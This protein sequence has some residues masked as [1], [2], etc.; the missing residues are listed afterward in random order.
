MW[1]VTVPAGEIRCWLFS[2]FKLCWKRSS[3]SVRLSLW[4][5]EKKKSGKFPPVSAC[6]AVLRRCRNPPH[7]HH[8]VTFQVVSKVR[9][10]AVFC[11]RRALCRSSSCSS[12]HTFEPIALPSDQRLQTYVHIVWSPL[13]LCSVCRVPSLTQT[14]ALLQSSVV[15]FVV[16]PK[17]VFRQLLRYSL[18]FLSFTKGNRSLSSCFSLFLPLL[19]GDQ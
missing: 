19:D 15:Q 1:S 16:A 4:G 8:H 18:Y 7:H 14:A 5:K 3:A 10:A 12:L 2:G 6:T 11:E 9:E 13:E 17:K